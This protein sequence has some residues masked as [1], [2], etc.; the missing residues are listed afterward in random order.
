MLNLNTRKVTITQDIKWLNKTYGEWIDKEYPD[1]E[2]VDTDSSVGP[3]L[4]DSD[5]Q[6]VV[7][8]NNSDEQLQEIP[9][10]LIENMTKI[11]E[12]ADSEDLMKEEA[13]PTTTS[14]SDDSDYDED[15]PNKLKRELVKKLLPLKMQKKFTLKIRKYLNNQD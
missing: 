8:S 13:K 14:D 1:D 15:E 4:S 7:M 6:T 9:S 11:T 10:Q 3:I 5:D 12:D 2:D